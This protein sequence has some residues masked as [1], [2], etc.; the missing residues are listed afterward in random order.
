MPPRLPLLPFLSL[1]LLLLL[2]PPVPS[3]LFL[4]LLQPVPS[5]LFLL[6][7]RLPPTLRRRGNIL[8]AR[9]DRSPS[10][11]HT[12]VVPDYL[13]R[14]LRYIVTFACRRRAKQCGW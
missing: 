11:R 3:P 2:L 10:L 6:L 4:L 7:L 9:L 1:L 8:S 14:Q 13:E 5:P 12:L